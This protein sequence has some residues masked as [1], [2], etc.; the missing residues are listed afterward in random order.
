MNGPLS[1]SGDTYTNTLDGI[2]YAAHYIRIG[3]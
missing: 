2:Q 1:G 3:Q